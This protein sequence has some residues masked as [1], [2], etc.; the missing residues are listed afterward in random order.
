MTKSVGKL[1]HTD[2]LYLTFNGTHL[3]LAEAGTVVNF[4]AACTF[5]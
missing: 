5:V 2:G 1:C 3:F 4:V